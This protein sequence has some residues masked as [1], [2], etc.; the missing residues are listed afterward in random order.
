MIQLTLRYYSSSIHS[1]CRYI[2]QTLLHIITSSSAALVRRRAVCDSARV[3]RWLPLVISSW[4]TVR[5]IS[6]FACICSPL[7]ALYTLALSDRAACFCL[8]ERA[9]RPRDQLLCVISAHAPPKCMPNAPQNYAFNWAI[10]LKRP[11]YTRKWRATQFYCW[12][13]LMVAINLQVFFMVN[14]FHLEWSDRSLL[15]NEINTSIMA[16]N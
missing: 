10:L 14:W 5:N 11:S 2:L 6:T 13:K 15:I 4:D 9:F 12:E 8:R 7:A 3:S 1:L 16:M